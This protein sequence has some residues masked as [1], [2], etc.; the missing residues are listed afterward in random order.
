[1]TSFE[2]NE[3]SNLTLDESLTTGISDIY[4]SFRILAEKLQE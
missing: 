1:L 2:D 4:S 3:R